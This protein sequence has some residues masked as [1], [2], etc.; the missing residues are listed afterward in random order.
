MVRAMRLTERNHFILEFFGEGA[1]RNT[2]HEG[3][4]V[5]ELGRE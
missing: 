5:F 2:R 1:V 4:N 3:E